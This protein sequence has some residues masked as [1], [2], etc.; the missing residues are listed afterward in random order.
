MNHYYVVIDTNVLVSAVL[1]HNSIP[2]FIINLAFSGPVIPVLNGEIEKE[3]REVLSRPK[4]HLTQD[5]VEDIVGE[6]QNRGLY[7]D[8]EKQDIELP[9]PK[10]VVFYEVM[11]EGS[12]TDDTFLVTGNGRHFPE[13]PYIVSPRQLME[14]I[15][16][17][18]NLNQSI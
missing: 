18:E 14:I 8:A 2:G 11:L 12:K 13:N 17:D 10:D 1:K 9:D 5:I 16:K 7:L 15:L 4:F 3:Y 6:F